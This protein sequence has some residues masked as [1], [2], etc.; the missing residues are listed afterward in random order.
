[1]GPRRSLGPPPDE[2]P[3]AKAERLR[4]FQERLKARRNSLKK[5]LKHQQRLKSAKANNNNIAKEQTKHLRRMAR[6]RRLSRIAAERRDTKLITHIRDLQKKEMNRFQEIA[7]PLRTK[8]RR[9]EQD[10]SRDK[11][12]P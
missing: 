7:K 12:Q 3:E 11:E 6:L 4:R 10:K 1:M 5:N 8:S 9:K 2:T